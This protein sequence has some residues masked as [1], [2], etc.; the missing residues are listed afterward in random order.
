MHQAWFG[1]SDEARAGL[2]AAGAAKNDDGSFKVKTGNPIIF[3]LGD[4]EVLIP[5]DTE[6]EIEGEWVK[7][8]TVLPRGLQIAVI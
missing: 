5:V 3:G 4:A 2:E 1:A 8:V 6:V 7:A